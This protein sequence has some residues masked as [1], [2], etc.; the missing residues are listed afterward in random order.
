MQNLILHI[1]HASIHIP[2]YDGFVSTKEIIQNELNLLTDW[3]TEELFDLSYH[4]VIAPFSRIFCDVERFSDDNLEIMS[5][6]GMGMCYTHTD[7][8]KPMR[9]VNEELRTRIKWDNY[10]KHHSKLNELTTQI[11]NEHGKVLIVDCHSFSDI[12]FQRDMNKELPRPDFCI[13]TDSFHTPI[14]LVESAKE[15]LESHG[16]IVEINRPYS[17]TIIP[18]KFYKVDENVM[19]IMIEVNRRLYLEEGLHRND[20]FILKLRKLISELIS[21][22]NSLA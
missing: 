10:D 5:S 17:G 4:K 19:G 11:L 15:F 21:M 6:V 13:G 9:V 3:Y 14:E 1:P 7:S 16:Y 18:S 12:P 2:N 8:G 22:L 20:K